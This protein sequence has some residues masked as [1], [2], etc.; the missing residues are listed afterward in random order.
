LHPQAAFPGLIDSVARFGRYGVHLFFVLSGFLIVG[1]LLDTRGT[2]DYY[3][4]FYVRRAL[5][6][7]PAYM[8]L[9]VVLKAVGY[10]SWRYV[11]ACVLYVAN[12]AGIFRAQTSEYGA[13]WSLAVEEQFYIFVPWFVRKRGNRGV[14]FFLLAICALCILARGITGYLRPNADAY[15]KIWDNADYL[16]YGALVALLLRLNVWNANNIRS[17]YKRFLLGGASTIWIFIGFDTLEHSGRVT[18][19]FLDAFGLLPAV[20]IFLGLL[21]WAVERNSRTPGSDRSASGATTLAQRALTFLG[22]ISYGLYLVHP[23]IFE[24]Y[25]RRIPLAFA[26]DHYFTALVPRALVCVTI[27]IALAY[28]SRVYFEEP[29]LKRKSGRTNSTNS[30]AQASESHTPEEPRAPHERDTQDGRLYR[31]A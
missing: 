25:D 12:M 22:F 6:I 20:A 15:F 26:K 2:A 5:R 17:V 7:L 1:G 3:S 31:G 23:A 27:A 21:L 18:R 10:I 16:A 24:T 30:A 13:L 4:R 9:I 29:F 8:L 11:A 19:A 14:L 28:L